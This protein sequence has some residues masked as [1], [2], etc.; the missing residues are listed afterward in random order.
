MQ[1]DVV[2]HSM[3][4][5]RPSP[6]LYAPDVFHSHHTS[7]ESQQPLCTLDASNSVPDVS[8][9][10]RAHVVLCR[11]IPRTRVG[12]PVAAHEQAAAALDQVGPSLGYGSRSLGPAPGPHAHAGRC[13]KGCARFPEGR[14]AQVRGVHLTA[15]SP[16]HSRDAWAQSPVPELA[17][18]IGGGAP[19]AASDIGGAAP[20]A[21]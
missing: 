19:W 17:C 12:P 13:R 1:P 21:G 2:V 10:H 20:W 3:L 5:C 8:L 9:C 11:R 7:R 15:G 14:G 6:R 16:N 18:A 4:V